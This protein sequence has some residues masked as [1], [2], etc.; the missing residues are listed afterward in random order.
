MISKLEVLVD[1]IGKL[2]GIHNPE[3]EC[4]QIRNPLMIKSYARAG[5]HV[6]TEKG[7][8][9]F[10]SFLSGYKAGLFDMDLKIRGKSRAGLRPDSTLENLLGVYQISP[11][12][13]DTVVSFVRRAL[14][15]QSI[16]KKTPLS[17][18]IE[19]EPEV[20]E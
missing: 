15:D 13:M 6:V 3:S 8:R 10:T 2:N 17:Y 11:A 1:A 20:N 5:K 14:A 9:V 18:F 12:A 16:S 4:Y 7:I 19:G